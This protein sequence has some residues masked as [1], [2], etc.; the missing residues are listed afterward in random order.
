MSFVHRSEE[1]NDDDT[2]HVNEALDVDHDNNMILED[3]Y[4]RM[5][6]YTS[7]SKAATA[8]TASH[9]LNPP[10]H[11]TYHHHR[12]RRHSSSLEKSPFHSVSLSCAES[13]ISFGTDFDQVFD[14]EVGAVPSWEEM[15]KLL[16]VPSQCSTLSASSSTNNLCSG[17]GGESSSDNLQQHSIRLRDSSSEM[18]LVF[19]QEIRQQQQD[20][21]GAASA[22]KTN[23]PMFGRRN[24]AASTVSNGTPL[25][26]LNEDA[27]LLEEEE[28]GDEEGSVRSESYYTKQCVYED[29]GL[30][31]PRV[32]GPPMASSVEPSPLGSSNS[33]N[34]Q[35]HHLL[36]NQ[37]K[38]YICADVN[39][40]NVESENQYH[41]KQFYDETKEATK[42]TS[43]PGTQSPRLSSD[44]HMNQTRSCLDLEQSLM[45]TLSLKNE[46][47]AS[48]E[49]SC[50]Q[51]KNAFNR[52]AKEAE[53]MPIKDKA[54]STRESEREILPRRD[55]ENGLTKNPPLLLQK[56]SLSARDTVLLTEYGLWSDIELWDDNP[57]EY[58]FEFDLSNMKSPSG[59]GYNEQQ[60]DDEEGD[61][62]VI[63]PDVFD[64]MIEEIDEIL[65]SRD[66]DEAEN[67]VDAREDETV[68]TLGNPDFLMEETEVESIIS[69]EHYAVEADALPQQSA[70]DLD[71]QHTTNVRQP[72]TTDAISVTSM[73]AK[74]R[75]HDENEVA[76]E[77]CSS[78]IERMLTSDEYS[79]AL[80]RTDEEANGAIMLKEANDNDAMKDH[81]EATKLDND[82]YFH[83]LR[84]DTQ[85]SID[86]VVKQWQDNTI[87]VDGRDLLRLDTD[88]IDRFDAF[89]SMIR[90][91]FPGVRAIGLLLLLC[92]NQ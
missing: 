29:K 64:R 67:R 6:P 30:L 14:N 53:N 87:M 46:L 45:Q 88:G 77:V 37:R 35:Q 41:Q 25:C 20:T 5:Y 47:L 17:N 38:T 9:P 3:Y 27:F 1:Y 26:S 44:H 24:R 19:D 80:Q 31:P 23:L 56:A 50:H 72:T 69:K 28:N 48:V 8:S 12:R 75:P 7:S 81:D 91:I 52:V 10:R 39:G 61:E 83:L 65:Q 42:S 33:N 13:D 40:A 63:A 59:G 57:C 11:N 32:F 49:R 21:H 43:I 85:R 36:L 86:L 22:F 90:S 82:M 60:D 15:R 51:S 76:S 92:S 66:D 62:D 4:S 73:P 74:K 54:S 68:S 89:Q 18:D 79:W 78:G 34:G 70:D 58:P 84:T 2:M 71:E 55:V 16:F